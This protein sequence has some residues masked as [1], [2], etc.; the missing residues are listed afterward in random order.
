MA[1]VFSKEKRSAI[2][3]GVKSQGNL[4]TEIRLIRIFRD[5]G[6]KGWR[7]H[8]PVFGRPDFVFPSTR[9]A[10]F[11]DGCFWHGCPLHGSLPVANREFWKRKLVRNQE[12][13]KEVREE[14]QK[15]GWSVLR[16]WQHELK[17]PQNAARRIKRSL[18]HRSA[19]RSR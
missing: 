4:A 19:I 15:A 6:I 18:A 12:R 3:S 2:M 5:H 9:L 10:V 11:V 16:I 13:D 17:T 14:L 1:D 8:T 7:R